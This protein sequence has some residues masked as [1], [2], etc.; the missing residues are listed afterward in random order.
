MI[1]KSDTVDG[2]R[3]EVHEE[4]FGTIRYFAKVDGS[5]LCQRG[6]MRL[7]TFSTVE[8]AWKAALEEIP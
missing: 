4:R 5:P 1:V 8:A 6:R 7:R 3:I 2:K